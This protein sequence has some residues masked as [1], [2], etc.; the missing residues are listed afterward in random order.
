MR[1]KFESKTFKLRI[2]GS[3]VSDAYSIQE[4]KN[5]YHR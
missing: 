5:E 1:H 2:D 4:E 3:F